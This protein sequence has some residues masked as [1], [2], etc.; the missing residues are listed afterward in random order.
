MDDSIQSNGRESGVTER[1]GECQTRGQ[2]GI[3]V[4]KVLESR[5]G[6]E[7]VEFDVERVQCEGNIGRIA[8]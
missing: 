8:C 2:V 7:T 6:E 5:V 3:S 4:D 1:V